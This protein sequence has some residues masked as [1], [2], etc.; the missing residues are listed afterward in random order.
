MRAPIGVLTV[1]IPPSFRS[2][3]KVF[4]FFS[5]IVS[6]VDSAAASKVVAEV[7]SEKSGDLLLLPKIPLLVLA[8]PTRALEVENP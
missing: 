7:L 3:F 4:F 1:K 6:G 2:S 8:V 5:Y